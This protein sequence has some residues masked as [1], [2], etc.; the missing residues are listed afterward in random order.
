MT[1]VVDN[2]VPAAPARSYSRYARRRP[3]RY[4]RRR[5][6]YNR[7]RR[8]TRR[9]RAFQSRRRLSRFLLG[10]IDPFSGQVDGA[11]VPDSNT[12]PST[13]VRI[14][15][16][17]A[18]L[19]TNVDGLYVA[20]F[21]P[22]LKNKKVVGT[23][24][25][26]ST[27]TW[28]ADYGGGTDSTRLANMRSS[29]ELYRTCAHGV[30]V[31]CTGAPTNVTGSLHVCV[32]APSQYGSTSWNFPRSIS[33]M[34]NCA[35]YQKFPL[36]ALTQQGL[37]IVNKVLDHNAF[38]YVDPDSTQFNTGT[39]PGVSGP[40]T[41]NANNG[42]T[43]VEIQTPG[44]A[45]IFVVIEGG[46]GLTALLNVEDCMHLEATPL[47]DAIDTST[48]PAMFS[49]QELEQ[50]SHLSSQIPAAHVDSENANYQQQIIAALS[51][52]TQ[53]A[54]RRIFS[55]YVLPGL[56]SA[57]YYGT[58]YAFSRAIGLPGITTLR[59]RSRLVGY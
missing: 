3:A 47:R 31:T 15:D 26:P 43:G 8:F 30:R 21:N 51:S 9:R 7:R 42:P 44:W 41:Y 33:E 6:R 46:N 25:T 39:S 4:A 22:F 2:S 53:A 12:Y 58:G 59:N 48:A 14:E 24:A 40:A 5:P 56:R 17:F 16:T 13:A 20:A 38:R 55:G 35:F 34:L 1:L 36:A 50:M 37:T 52:G 28:T 19:T 49:T 27:W 29:F 54:G 11:K 45:T 10:Q 32:Y 18:G 23:G 57:A